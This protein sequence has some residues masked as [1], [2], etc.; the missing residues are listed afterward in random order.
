MK[1]TATYLYDGTDKPR[2]VYETEDGLR[3]TP[4]QWQLM[5]FMDELREKLDT[6][7]ALLGRQ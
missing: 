2:L 3:F 6:L 7:N 4:E 5:T 1:A